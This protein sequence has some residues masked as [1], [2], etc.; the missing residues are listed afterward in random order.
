MSPNAVYGGGG[1]EAGGDE[2]R[3]EKDEEQE[4]EEEG[5]KAEEIQGSILTASSFWNKVCERKTMK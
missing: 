4:E 2:D 3:T 5:E 1:E